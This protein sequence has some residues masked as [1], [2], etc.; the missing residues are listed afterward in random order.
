[1]RPQKEATYCQEWNFLVSFSLNF[2][3]RKERSTELFVE[4]FGSSGRIKWNG[5]IYPKFPSTILTTLSSPDLTSGKGGK[6]APET[7]NRKKGES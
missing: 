5:S 2:T 4:I 3:K 6:Y 7:E 1:M